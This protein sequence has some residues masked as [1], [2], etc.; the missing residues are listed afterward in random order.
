MNKENNAKENLLS[1]GKV[2]KVKILLQESIIYTTVIN[3]KAG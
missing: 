2:F 1:S 3:K